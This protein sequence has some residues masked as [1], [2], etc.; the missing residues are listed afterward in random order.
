MMHRIRQASAIIAAAIVL[1]YLGLVALSEVKRFAPFA[2]DTNWLIVG[3]FI[4]GVLFALISDRAI[5]SMFLAAVLAVIVFIGIWGFFFWRF[6]GAYFS[7]FELMISNRFFAEV[8]PRTLLMFSLSTI[9]GIIAAVI[10]MLVIP[11]QYRP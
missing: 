10:V 7:L 6:F 1:A 8:F 3:A 5:E 11:D 2:A 4:C 9:V